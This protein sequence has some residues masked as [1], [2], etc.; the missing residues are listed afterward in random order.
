MRC[1]R[2][3][4]CAAAALAPRQHESHNIFVLAV[5]IGGGG[6]MPLPVFAAGGLGSA[7]H[8]SASF[9][10]AAIDV[11]T[12]SPTSAFVVVTPGQPRELFEWQATSAEPLPLLSVAGAPLDAFADVAELTIGQGVSV[13]NDV[14]TSRVGRAAAA[15]GS[16]AFSL[17]PSP[18]PRA[19]TSWRTADGVAGAKRPRLATEDGLLHPSASPTVWAGI[20]PAG[21]TPPIVPS[22]RGFSAFAASALAPMSATGDSRHSLAVEHYAPLSP[23]PLHCARL[24][25]RHCAI[26]AAAREQGVPSML[27]SPATRDVAAFDDVFAFDVDVGTTASGTTGNDNGSTR[28]AL[29]PLAA[30]SADFGIVPMLPPPPPADAAT[31]AAAAALLAE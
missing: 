25:H 17:A 1:L 4:A 20:G 18:S 28:G 27:L 13:R 16:G 30:F 31:Y 8:S 19:E 29:S 6:D 3:P 10:A 11:P 9:S 7:C 22:R 12:F 2:R 24:Q 15:G 26:G 23:A 21:P 5:V 14:T